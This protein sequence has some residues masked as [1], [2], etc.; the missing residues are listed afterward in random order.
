M[1]TRSFVLYWVLICLGVLTLS[2]CDSNSPAESDSDPSTSEFN[3]PRAIVQ[4]RLSDT[5]TIAVY[6]Q[7][8]DGPRQTMSM[9]SSSVSIQLSGLSIGSHIFTLI[10]EYVLDADSQNPVT[11]VK[12]SKSV[13]VSSGSNS[14]SYS[15][16]DFVFSKYDDDRDGISNLDEMLSG[17]SAPVVT[18]KSPLNGATGVLE[19]TSITATFDDPMIGSSLSTNSFTVTGASAGS[20][21][22]AV[23]YD[24]ATKTATFTP[25]S[26]LKYNETYTAT[27]STSVQNSAS[28]GLASEQS[29]SFTI[30]PP[31]VLQVGRIPTLSTS[32]SP[33]LAYNDAGDGVA[34]WMVQ[35]VGYS[36][37]YSMY[38]SASDTWSAEALLSST[39]SSEPQLASNGTGFALVWEGHDDIDHQIYGSFYNGSNWSIPVIIDTE[40]KAANNP[41]LASNG[42]GYAVAWY[43]SIAGDYRIFGSISTDAKSWG[44]PVV[45][46]YGL[47]YAKYPKI[48]SNGSQYAVIW[49]ESGSHRIGVNIYNGDWGITT[50]ILLD[51]ETSTKDSYE[52]DIASNGSGFSVVW[53]NGGSIYN[54]TYYNSGTFGWGPITE[55]DGSTEVAHLGGASISLDGSEF[56]IA[57]NGTG[58]ATIFTRKNGSFNDVYAV[59]NTAGD[60]SWG[61]PVVLESE[62]N[63]INGSPMIVS[64]GNS[65]ATLWSQ[66]DGSTT[67]DL[68]SSV[69]DGSSWSVGEAIDTGSSPISEGFRLSG[70]GSQYIATWAQQLDNITNVYATVYE[71]TPPL[72]SWSQVQT[73]ETI[74]QNTSLPTIKAHPNGGA[75]VAWSQIDSGVFT[76]TFNTSNWEGELAVGRSPGGSA[77]HPSLLSNGNG[78]TLALWKQKSSNSINL[79]GN[80]HEN[81]VWKQPK[82]LYS[83]SRDIEFE[84]ETDGTGFAVTWDDYDGTFWRIYA[85][86]FDGTRWGTVSEVDDSSL[87]GSADYGRRFS[88]IAS[89]GN[90]YMIVYS[91]SDGSGNYDVYAR[92]YSGA[93][94]G[95]PVV[96]N[97]PLLSA[98]TAIQPSISTNGT[99]YLAVWVPRAGL[100]VDGVDAYSSEFNGI[101]WSTSELFITGGVSINST[102]SLA[103]NGTDYLAVW[104]QDDGA[105]QDRAYSNLYTAGSWG[106]SS[107]LDAGTTWHQAYLLSA[108]SNGSGYAVVWDEYTGTV[109]S[110][111]VNIYDGKSWEGPVTLDDGS[112][113]DVIL[114]NYDRDF[115]STYAGNYAVIWAREDSSGAL[116]PYVSVYN[117]AWSTA[118]ALESGAGSVDY[119]NIASDGKGF[120][121]AWIQKDSSGIHHA[122]ENRYDPVNGWSGTVILDIDLNNSAFDLS[123]GASSDGYMAIWT[124]AEPIGDPIVRSP[125]AR[126]G[127]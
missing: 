79:Y 118:T 78:R 102:I 27:L 56:S 76:H 70:S 37:K 65:Y 99:G 7:V 35:D 12:S 84:A 63:D 50:A 119:L 31:P 53:E 38:D 54:R 68:F 101:G 8:D 13:N 115:I 14:L 75:T 64:N 85:R 20:V 114:S 40:T 73:L 55:I 51:D 59:V 109:D 86:I 83:G 47:L 122:M 108:I 30:S 2:G 106:T 28:I 19:A 74:T 18:A 10:M 112:S 32:T 71:E 22:G 90:G 25:S 105:S 88:R 72:N 60:S 4:S 124:Q 1:F 24:D 66:Y 121:T 39:V 80:I 15:D 23:S 45:I 36:L 95:A 62:L 17:G 92:Q 61:K 34:V 126:I 16:S 44:P 3:L 69:Y 41:V 107:T 43:Q 89:N 81:G 103:S 46:D 98:G 57:S 97:T 93:T 11:L 104:A 5:G 111:V 77:Y 48:V 100:H 117:G 113:G 82:L 127:F 49:R 120:L 67:Y 125:W 94:W 116:D 9:G 123:L 6:M 91:Q 26:I 110:V 21:A 42:T 87:A 58:Y 29:W 52:Y 33:I 96:L